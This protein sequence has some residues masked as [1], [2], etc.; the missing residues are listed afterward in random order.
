MTRRGHRRKIEWNVL[1]VFVVLLL[2]WMYIGL[3]IMNDIASTN[4]AFISYGIYLLLIGIIG[5][6]FGSGFSKGYESFLLFIAT[7]LMID[8]VSPP[9]VIQESVEPSAEILAIWGSDTFIYA[10]G[11]GIGLSHPMAWF[12]TY[13]ITPAVGVFIMLFFLSG[14]R[15]RRRL[16]VMFNGR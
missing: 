3:P 15:L 1:V 9:M 13:I 2:G 8:I 14:K 11:Q 12:M 16:L 5:Y 4:G 10:I 7:I 6:V